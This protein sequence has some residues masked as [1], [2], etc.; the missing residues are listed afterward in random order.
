MWL[1]RCQRDSQEQEAPPAG[2]AL[3]PQLAPAALSWAVPDP[4][5]A[6]QLT[7][8]AGAPPQLPAP[9]NA[10]PFTMPPFP[11][12]SM[13]PGLPG[14]NALQV[15]ISSPNF[16]PSVQVKGLFTELWEGS[17]ASGIASF[18]MGSADPVKLGLHLSF[19]GCAAGGHVPDAA[20]EQP[21]AGAGPQ[22]SRGQPA[23]A[24]HA[25]G[26]PAPDVRHLCQCRRGSLCTG[27][28]ASSGSL[29]PR[30]EQHPPLCGTHCH[31]QVVHEYISLKLHQ[32]EPRI[33]YNTSACRS[34][35]VK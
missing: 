16:L 29:A 6:A 27:P 9:F 13:P 8:N 19:S 20:D 14:Q 4:A 33:C 34:C 22:D 35:I 28:G 17:R 5:A 31:L 23:F 1:K 26:I 21:A 3:Q 7:A 32:F 12:P 15:R 30:S 24:P 11:L 25:H 2:P 18:G 10:P